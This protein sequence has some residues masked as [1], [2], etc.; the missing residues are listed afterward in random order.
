MRHVNNATYLDVLD[1]TLAFASGAP[2][3][4]RPPV[5]YQVEYL[6]PALPGTTISVVRSVDPAGS[7][8][9]F[10]DERGQELAR[11]RVTER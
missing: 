10:L 5:R 2:S 9:R 6:R 8:F 1:E 7:A 4:P 3:G 11:A